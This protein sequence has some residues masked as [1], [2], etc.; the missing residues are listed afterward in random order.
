ME[1]TDI[2]AN[3]PKLYG[4]EIG[5]SSFLERLTGS[6]LYFRVAQCATSGRALLS[7]ALKVLAYN[8][9]FTEKNLRIRIRKIQ[10]TR[11]AAMFFEIKLFSKQLKSTN[12]RAIASAAESAKAC[13]EVLQI[14]KRLDSKKAEALPQLFVRMHKLLSAIRTN[15]NMPAAPFWV[16][17]TLGIGFSAYA[18]A[19]GAATH[20]RSTAIG[21]DMQQTFQNDRKEFVNIHS[22]MTA[23]EKPVFSFA[24]PL[25]SYQHQFLKSSL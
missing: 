5:H 2:D 10:K 21:L 7:R 1:S 13:T 6:C 20:K 24:L 25:K 17:Y 12:L 15:I 18:E 23:L 16:S 22:R 3:F 19:K 14:Q 8:S 9:N 11:F 4:W